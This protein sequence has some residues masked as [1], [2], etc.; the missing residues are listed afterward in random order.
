[1]PGKGDIR[2][3]DNLSNVRLT[4]TVNI[5]SVKL[6]MNL[7]TGT[8]VLFANDLHN[9]TPALG[10]LVGR[11]TSDGFA[12][13]SA[14]LGLIGRFGVPMFRVWV[15]NPGSPQ[16]YRQKLA[17]SGLAGRL[18]GFVLPFGSEVHGA[19][20]DDGRE[21]QSQTVVFEDGPCVPQPVKLPASTALMLPVGS[22]VE[23]MSTAMTMA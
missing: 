6:L 7:R 20:L 9:A 11:T 12:W 19:L 21:T 22:S 14:A 10:T 3:S 8:V 13:S 5:I 4:P 16:K 1:M 15:H 17:P 18:F 23:G 2:S